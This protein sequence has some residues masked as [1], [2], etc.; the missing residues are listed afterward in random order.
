VA[1]EQA[2]TLFVSRPP[3]RADGLSYRLI[4]HNLGLS[5]NTV[6]KIVKREA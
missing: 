2:P 1:L 5:T 4:A 3:G 6:M